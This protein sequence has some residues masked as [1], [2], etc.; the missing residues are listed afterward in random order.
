MMGNGRS[1][2]ISIKEN[3][4]SVRDYGRGIPLDKVIDCVGKM[5]TGGKYDSEAFQRSIGLNGVGTKAVNA[6]SKYFKIQSIRNG[7]C[8]TVE[9]SEGVIIKDYPLEAT[10]ELNGTKV[11]FVPDETIFGNYKFYVE[12]IEK[13]SWNYAY[14]N[15]GLTIVFNGQRKK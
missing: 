11:I 14:L 6:L 15:S 12:Y 1:I 9:F 7:Q 8:K 3:Q 2:E 10:D 4:V 5:N 13:M